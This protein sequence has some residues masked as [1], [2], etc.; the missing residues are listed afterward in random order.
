MEVLHTHLIYPHFEKHEGIVNYPSTQ[1][2]QGYQKFHLLIH[3]NIRKQFNNVWYLIP[4][5]M[6]SEQLLIPDK[7]EEQ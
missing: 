5:V 7:Y 3:T 6:R 4:V 1:N 2:I